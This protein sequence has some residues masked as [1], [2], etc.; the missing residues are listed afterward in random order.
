MNRKRLLLAALA[1]LLVLSLTYAFWAMPRQEKAPPRTETPR[2]AA[3]RPVAG[4]K[5]PPPADRLHLGLLAQEPQPFSGAERDIFRFHGGWAPA[6][7][8]VET[9]MPTA[10]AAPP[11]P[12]PPPP[13][14]PEEILR[15]IVAQVTFLGFL[16][17]GG[18]RT[19]FLSKGGEVFLVKAGEA[20]GKDKTLL[21]KEISGRE[22]VIGWVQGPET[23]RVQLIEN[24]ALKPATMSP[25]AESP[26]TGSGFRPG[27]MSIP[28]RRGL[29]PPRTP[30]RPVPAPDE[31][32]VS[33]DGMQPPDDGV[34]QGEPPKE[35]AP[36]GEGNGNAN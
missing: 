34:E 29:L 15:G 23:V 3:K 13:P 26:S 8:E 21:A 4:K 36:A 19:V 9:V 1:G 12:P 28:P 17:K 25:G 27:G 31:E 18:V 2:P 30:A 14:T 6:L 5:E 16:D 32:E 35:E 7:Q 22:L 10:V 33:E 20:F 11:P 24:E